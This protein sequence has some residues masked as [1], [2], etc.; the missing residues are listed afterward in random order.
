VSDGQAP[1][2][3][4]CGC[5]ADWTPTPENRFQEG[6]WSGHWLECYSPEGQYEE[7]HLCPTCVKAF[8]EAEGRPWQT[9]GG[10]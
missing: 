3:R 4:L 2:C 9:G 6:C 10:A 5:K 7:V 8:F 1:I